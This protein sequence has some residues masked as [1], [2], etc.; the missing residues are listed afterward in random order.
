MEVK[1]ASNSLQPHGLS[2]EFSRPEDWNGEPF[3]SPGDLLNPGIEARSPTLQVDSLLFEP[4]EKPMNTGVRSLS[5]LQGIFPTQELNQGLLHCRWIFYQ[6][7]YQGNFLFS[8][9]PWDGKGSN[10]SLDSGDG[11]SLWG[12]QSYLRP[13]ISQSRTVCEKITGFLGYYHYILENE[14]WSSPFNIC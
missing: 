13:W 4:P 2:M 7:S 8:Y 6:L 11:S 10:N 5:S 1:V 14:E 12:W 9:W 3:P